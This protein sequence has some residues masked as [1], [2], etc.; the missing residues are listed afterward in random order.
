MINKI[1]NIHKKGVALVEV[2]IAAAIISVGVLAVSSAYSTYV[3]Y[4]FSNQYNVQVSY[5]M[6]EA[7]EAVSFFRDNSW[8]ANIAHLSTTTTYYLT[9]SGSSFATTTTPQYVDG[10]FLRSITVSDVKRDA[11]QDIA[12][13]GT[14]DPNIKHVTTSVSFSYKG[15]TTTKSISMYITNLYDN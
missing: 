2:V 13:A 7:L 1:Y 12:S 9:F 15:A 14:Y 5:M 11:N 4:A 10:K 6:E 3:S 8:A